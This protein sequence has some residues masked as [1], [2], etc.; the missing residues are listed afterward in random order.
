MTRDFART[1]LIVSV[2]VALPIW[3]GTQDVTKLLVVVVLG[4]FAAMLIEGL[5]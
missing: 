5:R 3:F 4:M 1:W 2:A